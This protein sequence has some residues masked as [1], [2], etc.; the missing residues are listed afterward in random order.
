MYQKYTILRT[1]IPGIQTDP[2]NISYFF[3]F[4]FFV[5]FTNSCWRNSGKKIYEYLSII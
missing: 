3:V 4:F 5:N 2:F 1:T